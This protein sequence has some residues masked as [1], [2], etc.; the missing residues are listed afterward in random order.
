MKESDRTLNV[1]LNE[2][3]RQQVQV[4]RH[5]KNGEYSNYL[6]GITAVHIKQGVAYA[7]VG[8]GL[9]GRNLPVSPDVAGYIDAFE[10]SVYLSASRAPGIYSLKKEGTV[11]AQARVSPHPHSNGD[12]RSYIYSCGK[13]RDDVVTLYELIRDGKI[14]PEQEQEE[15]EQIEGALPELQRL[16]EEVPRLR[17]Q[18][19]ETAAEINTIKVQLQLANNQLNG[20]RTIL[21][22]QS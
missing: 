12:D 18:V 17:R 11:L 4:E 10:I 16:R 5:G 15:F 8:W 19:D 6:V 13:E 2:E 21:G 20:A 22:I 3:G 14:R 9:D 1:R 7:Q